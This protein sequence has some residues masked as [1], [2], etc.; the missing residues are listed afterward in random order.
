MKEILAIPLLKINS[1]PGKADKQ[2]RLVFA[3][4]HLYLSEAEIISVHDFVSRFKALFGFRIIHMKQRV[5][6]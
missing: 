5:F 2:Q 4:A 6:S 3:P 1:S